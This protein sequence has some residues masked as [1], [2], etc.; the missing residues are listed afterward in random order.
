MAQI[1]CTVCEGSGD[2]PIIDKYGSEKFIITCPECF[3]LGKMDDEN[4]GEDAIQFEYPPSTAAS[5]KSMDA[6]R[7]NFKLRGD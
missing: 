2:Y 7:L 1:E 6:L 3:G 4:E 5:I